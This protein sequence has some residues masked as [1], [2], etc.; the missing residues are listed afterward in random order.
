M[1]SCWNAGIHVGGGRGG[2]RDDDDDDVMGGRGAM[3]VAACPARTRAPSLSRE[4]S[5]VSRTHWNAGDVTVM[6]RWCHGDVIVVSRCHRHC[7]MAI[8][9]VAVA[10]RNARIPIP[11][12]NGGLKKGACPPPKSPD[13]METD[14]AWVGR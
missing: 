7:A 11:I 3:R 12:P 5:P 8:I 14:V 1:P 2:V 6:S 10:S 9:L 13:V 4:E